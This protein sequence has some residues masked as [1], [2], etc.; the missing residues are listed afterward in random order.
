[1]IPKMGNKN[2]E[3]DESQHVITFA[4]EMSKMTSLVY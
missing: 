4:D 2:L 1:M 3:K